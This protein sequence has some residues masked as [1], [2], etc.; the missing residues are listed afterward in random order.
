MNMK[1]FLLFPV[2]MLV[3]SS[4]FSQISEQNAE[5]EKKRMEQ[6]NAAMKLEDKEGWSRRAGIGI[7]L[8]QLININ[9]YVGAGS[10]RLGIGGAINYKADYKRGLFSWKNDMLV[11]L[12][13]QRIGSGTISATSNEKVPFEKALDMLNLNTNLSYLVRDSSPWAYSLDMGLRTQLLGSFLDSASKK[14]YLKDLNVGPYNTSLVSEFFSPALI[15]I[16]PGIKYSK[17][18]KYQ[19]FLSPVAGQILV[20][21]D[22]NI[23]NLG[24][25]GTELKEG[26]TTEYEQIKFSLG[27]LFKAAYTN[28]YFDKLNMT[29]ELS[30]F[31]D[32]LDEPQN[33]DVV[34]MNSFGVEIVKGL[35]LGLRLDLYYDH[36]KTNYI[37]DSDAVGGISGT[38]KRINIIEQLLLSYS[39]NF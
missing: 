9:P 33:I 10:N 38:G 39:R 23:A 37:S 24:V 30:L 1:L 5:Q 2:I 26:S 19:F 16:A 34:W 25:H 3:F 7:D 13:V 36:N 21:A 18:K 11:N 8:G 27:A 32:Y 15:T 20:I 29:S 6:L 4:A 28:I 31:S 14:I 12:T 35:N 17:T 22:Q